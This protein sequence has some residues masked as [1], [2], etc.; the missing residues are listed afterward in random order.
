MLSKENLISRFFENIDGSDINFR[1]LK[2]STNYLLNNSCTTEEE[3]DDYVDIDQHLAKLFSELRET[4]AKYSERIANLF[5]NSVQHM[6]LVPTLRQYQV[7][8]VKWMLYREKYSEYL[9]TEYIPIRTNRNY[10]RIF[11]ENY[12]TCTFYLNPRI[13]Y[14]MENDPGDIRLPTGGILADE[15]GLGKTVEMLSLI[16]MN[17]NR[18]RVISDSDDKENSN[19]VTSIVYKSD[20]NNMLCLCNKTKHNGGCEKFI[21]CI[22]CLKLQHKKCVLK[23][24]KNQNNK[25]YICPNCWKNM[26]LILSSATIIVSPVA[27]KKQWQNEIQKH[28]ANDNLRVLVYDGITVTGWI[29]PADLATYDIILTDYNVLRSEVHYINNNDR[30]GLRNDKKF[31][32]PTSPLTRIKYWRVCLDEAQ[33]VETTTT[34]CAVMVNSL[35]TVHRWSVT[36]TPIQ[37]HIDNLQGLLYFLDCHPYTDISA[38]K[39]LSLPYENGN[40]K[41]LLDVLEKIM[42]R[43]CKTDVLDQVDIPPQTEIVHYVTMSDLES[44]FYKSQHE[45]YSFAFYE[46]TRKLKNDAS[47]SKINRHTLNLVSII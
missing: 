9:P 25:N 36:G 14:M 24:A 43:T 1:V 4:R 10:V 40:S 33:M 16:L 2:Q 22:K 46:K 31:L 11:D 35:P 42:W 21:K 19:A 38:W 23:H 29:S 8:A 34:N 37:K 39:N 41:P 17:R 3:D 13:L 5:P 28:I 6:L 15:M 30:S 26:D 12:S 45:N 18:K 7:E 47:M 32:N 27:I 44:F 20:L